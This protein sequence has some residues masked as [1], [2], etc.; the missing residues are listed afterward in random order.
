M[1]VCRSSGGSEWRG[2]EG[3]RLAV[4]VGHFHR[5]SV[6]GHS[7]WLSI[8]WALPRLTT[9]GPRSVSP[10]YLHPDATQM[11]YCIPSCTM[12][13]LP[14]TSSLQDGQEGCQEQWLL[15]NSWLGVEW[16]GVDEG[17]RKGLYLPSIDMG[18]GIDMSI[19]IR[20]LVL[21]CISMS[22]QRFHFLTRLR[23]MDESTIHCSRRQHAS[24]TRPPSP[25]TT[26]HPPP[27]HSTDTAAARSQSPGPPSWI[28]PNLF[29]D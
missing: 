2:P 20:T 17:E 23:Q 12:R 21:F 25:L 9:S 26:H 18:M 1:R 15:C 27:H 16:G 10:L 3:R 4:V 22:A 5:I 19:V 13:P 28:V 6:A 29:I 8:G 11:L 24:P 14:D 7:C